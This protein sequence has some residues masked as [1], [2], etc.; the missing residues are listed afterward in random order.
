MAE[1]DGR[2]TISDIDIVCT[3]CFEGD[4]R[5][6]AV[7]YC[8]ECQEF[9]C[10]GCTQHHGRLRMS[11]SHKLL[12]KNEAKQGS[13]FAVK[14]KCLYHPDRDIEMYCEEHDMVYCLK[15]IAS[16]HRLVFILDPFLIVKYL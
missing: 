9:L 15:C 4:I 14:A 8:P 11:R 7:K 3:P 5:E 12:D 6:Q 13:H 1:V 2:S 16:D 10:T